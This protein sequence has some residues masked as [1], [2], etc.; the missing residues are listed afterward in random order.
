M[1]IYTNYFTPSV[2]Y[3]WLI[4]NPLVFLLFMIKATGSRE[5]KAHKSLAEF[6]FFHHHPPIAFLHTDS[7]VSGLA[8]N[9]TSKRDTTDPP[10]G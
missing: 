9:G 8:G 4:I 1:T 5:F 6:R 2:P 3:H 10:H 7:T